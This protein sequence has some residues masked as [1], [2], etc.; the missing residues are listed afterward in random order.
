M[1]SYKTILASA[2]MAIGTFGFT[3]CDGD[4]ELPPVFANGTGSESLK[5]LE[6]NTTIIDLKTTYWDDARNYAQTVGTTADG[7]HVLIRGRVV[8]NDSAGNVYK[9]L[10]IE[11]ATAAL[12]ISVD[13][14]KIYQLLPPGTDITIDM[15]GMTVGKYN[16]L[17]QMGEPKPYNNEMEVSFMK[18]YKLRGAI[19]VNGTPDASKIKPTVVTIADVA[20]WKNDNDSLRKY[21]S[22]WVRFNNV[23]WVGGGTLQWGD[24]DDKGAGTTANRQIKDASGRT[25]TARNSGYSTFWRQTLPAG[26]GDVECLLSFYGT[27][28]QLTFNNYTDCFNFTGEADTPIGGGDGSAEAPY[29]VAQI[30][31]GSS[32]SDKWV[33][34]FIVGYING[35][36]F[37]PTFG[38]SG[39]VA[40]NLVLAPTADCTIADL[41]IPV[42][43]PAGNMRTALNLADHPDYLGKEVTL[44]GNC[45]TYFG[46]NGFKEVSG[47]SWGSTGGETPDTP[48]A[49]TA[50]F[51]KATSITAGKS[52]LLVASSQCAT[53]LSGDYGYLAQAGVTVNGTQIS[54][55][56]ANAFTFEANGS[57]Y[58]IKQPNG[59]YL[60]MTGTYNSFNT[61]ATPAEGGEWKV[62]ANADGTFT[63]TNTT[64]DK[65][66]QYSAE[67]KSFG[68]YPDV[69]GEFPTLYEK[70]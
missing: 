13:T 62:E 42:A 29:T 56:A 8:S 65:S 31:A 15:T 7:E 57:N 35:K 70:Q 58:S 54:G 17:F 64:M 9:S 19:H 25:L 48:V 28:W 59:K 27:D 32:G 30:K 14:T 4:P 45:A 36:A 50:T 43:L 6:A 53:P 38:A 23:S 47:Y 20:S 39:A 12:S 21:Q 24:E 51:V 55:D 40:T 16:G 33:T 5:P 26:T 10:V 37:E 63:I 49:S 22:R 68:S 34:G 60:I 67:Y 61:A 3:S 52:Y 11:D 2:L 18:Y 66:I 1:K 41:C 44:K 69:R 46:V